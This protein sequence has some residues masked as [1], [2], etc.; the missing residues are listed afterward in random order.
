M[1]SLHYTQVNTTTYFSLSLSL[2]KATGYGGTVVK[3]EAGDKVEKMEPDDDRELT[4]RW[5][6]ER[7]SQMEEPS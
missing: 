3:S 4:I 7:S 2:F 1:L 6:G 5:V